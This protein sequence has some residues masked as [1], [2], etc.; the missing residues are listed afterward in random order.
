VFSTAQAVITNS[1]VVNNGSPTSAYG[2]IWVSADASTH[3]QIWFTT[4]YRNV[5][6]QGTSPGIACTGKQTEVV[7]SMFVENG[8]ADTT[9]QATGNCQ[10]RNTLTY[11]GAPVAGQGNLA[12]NPELVNPDAGDFHPRC[13]SPAV[14]ATDRR[15]PPTGATAWD[16]EGRQR[17]CPPAIGALQPAT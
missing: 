14:D 4:V 9:S 13:D 6:V 15:V 17:S 16:L 2:G 10:F 1:L 12:V 5:S 7:D 3:N 8:L 11:P